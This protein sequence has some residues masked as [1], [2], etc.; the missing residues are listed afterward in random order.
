MSC[1]AASSEPR[2]RRWKAWIIGLACGVGVITIAVPG[3]LLLNSRPTVCITVAGYV[4][5]RVSRLVAGQPTAQMLVWPRIAVTNNSGRTIS[6]QA[7]NLMGQPSPSGDPFYGIAT[8]ASGDWKVAYFSAPVGPWLTH[9]AI[10]TM[11]PGQGVC[12]TAMTTFPGQYRVVFTYD[13]GT[14][15]NRIWKKVPG[16]IAARVPWSHSSWTVTSEVISTGIHST[17]PEQ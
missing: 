6:Y 9:P 10:R 5:N 2:K 1:D 11:S 8:N 15:P 16:W 14:T 17:D 7:F 13:N 12:F 3:M 4:T